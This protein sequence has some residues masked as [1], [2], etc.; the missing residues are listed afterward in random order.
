MSLSYN[1]DLSKM[2]ALTT[3]HTHNADNPFE[4]FFGPV[5]VQDG[6]NVS[7]ESVFA[8]ETYNLPSA[9]KGRNL[10]LGDMLDFLITR[11]DD[12]YTSRVMPFRQTDQ[13]H[14]SWNVFR[15][16]KTMADLQPHQGI[17]RYI[18][19][20]SEE[21]SDSLVRRGLA[22]IVEHGFWSTE[23]G[24]QHYLLNLENITESVHMTVYYGVLH[25][26]LSGKGHWKEWHGL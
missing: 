24:K 21:H 16:N 20:E 25:A 26:L 3:G 23:R 17:P 11:T 14:V 1:T 15:F 8:H 5:S 18:T 6:Q 22:F 7:A 2:P 9:Y 4:P 19:A 13:I 12:W 10:F